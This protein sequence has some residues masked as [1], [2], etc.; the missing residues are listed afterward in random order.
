MISNYLK[1][2]SNYYL[3][4]YT[5][6]KKKFEEILKKKINK[7]FFQ[8]KI[9]EDQKNEFLLEIENIIKYF[10]RIG[11]FNEERLLEITFQNYT[12]RGYSQKKI[13]YKLKEAKFNNILLSNFLETKFNNQEFSELLIINYLK[14]SKIIEKQKKLNIPQNQLFDKVLKKLA[15]Q[16]FDYENSFKILQRLISDGKSF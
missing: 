4:R 1:T 14:K 9:T 13:I 12:N 8:N 15:I 2:Y 6:T 16:G 11:M 3:S 5:V 7:D 10:K